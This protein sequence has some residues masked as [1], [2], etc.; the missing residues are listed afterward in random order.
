MYELFFYGLY[1]F[2]RG[3][4]GSEFRRVPDLGTRS[5]LSGRIRVVAGSGYLI[6]DV[7]H[8]FCVI[9]LHCFFLIMSL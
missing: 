6:C 3:G 1:V 2:D 7:Q 9:A 8:C 4:T 5:L